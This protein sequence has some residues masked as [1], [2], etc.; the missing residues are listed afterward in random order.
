MLDKEQEQ[1]QEEVGV[2]VDAP[3]AEA[4]APPPA[5]GGNNNTTAAAAQELASHAKNAKDAVFANGGYPAFVLLVSF[6]F[7]IQA[8]IV[9]GQGTCTSLEGYAVAGGV[10]SIMF[11]G[12]FLVLEKKEQL[13]GKV[14]VGLAAFLFIWWA[15]LA[16]FTTYEDPFTTPGNGYFAAWAGAILSLFMVM[17]EVGKV[18]EAVDKF[19]Q[20]G[21]K[22]AILII[23]SLMVFFGGISACSSGSCGGREG[24]AVAVGIIS[25]VVAVV[26][27]AIESK[28]DATQSRFFAIFFIVWW[29]IA[30]SILTFWGPFNVAGNGYFG[31]VAGLVASILLISPA[32]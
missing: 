3:Y 11:S 28:L 26:R 32:N 9:C 23:G 8:A 31:C 5:P 13:D 18:R 20:L 15:F 10:I 14:R 1:G 24:Y 2:D 16:G 7:M 6:V 29:A 27:V 12:I 22:Y 21:P 17:N 25:F 30:F 19:A 4:E